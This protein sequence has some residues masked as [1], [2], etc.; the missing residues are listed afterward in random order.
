[1]RSN[2]PMTEA[3]IR[4]A[5]PAVFQERPHGR[6][7]DRY[8]LI[9]TSE[10]LAHL[11]AA[12]YGVSRA[13]QKHTRVPG[14]M[15]Y[16]RHLLALRPLQAFLK[17][18]VG[19]VVPEIIL[20]NG[21]DGFT[22]YELSAGLFRLVCAN[23]LMVGQTIAGFTVAHRGNIKEEVLENT[24]KVWQS[25]PAV[26]TFI[27]QA[28]AYEMPHVEQERFAKDAMQIRYGDKAPYEAK[29]LLGVRRVEDNHSDLWSVYNRVQE[30]LMGG[31]IVGRSA[32]GRRVLSKPIA[33]VTRDVEYNRKLWDLVAGYLEVA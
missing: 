16:A 10:V 31:G 30:N 14:S 6:T 7:T 27:E 15:P 5:A 25:F 13:Q 3:Q 26:A 19:D 33:R 24:K 29:E 32:L 2:E 20:V 1:M 23:G 18:I 4:E 17:P 8:T 22:S 9:P 28:R 12:G 11:Q 21:H